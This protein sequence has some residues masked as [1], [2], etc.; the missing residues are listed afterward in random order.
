MAYQMVVSMVAQLDALLVEMKVA[1][2][3]QMKVVWLASCLVGQLVAWKDIQL[4]VLLV[5]W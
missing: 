1:W 3:E 2:T 4:V 5:A